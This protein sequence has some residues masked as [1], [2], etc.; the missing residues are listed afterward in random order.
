MTDV[1]RIER[2]ERDPGASGPPPIGPGPEGLDVEPGGRPAI[3]GQ[4]VA[5]PVGLLDLLGVDKP[6][7]YALERTRWLARFLLTADRRS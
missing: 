2:G 4:P 7:Q 5:N 3:V 6:G 1:G